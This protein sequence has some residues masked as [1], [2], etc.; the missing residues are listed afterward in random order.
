MLKGGWLHAQST[1]CLGTQVGIVAHD[2]EAKRRH[3]LQHLASDLAK[4][5]QAKGL[6]REARHALFRTLCCAPVPGTHLLIQ[7]GNA[8]EGAQNQ[9]GAMVGNLSN[10]MVWRIGHHNA[11]LRGGIKINRVDPNSV[12]YNQPTALEFTDLLGGETDPGGQNHLSIADG[13]VMFVTKE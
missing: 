4:P 8:A 13:G 2:A 9:C 3:T 7:P 6:A 11:T 12:A 1:D 10:T 5:N